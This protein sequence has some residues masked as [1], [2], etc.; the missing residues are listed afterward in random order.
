[1]ND[2]RPEMHRPTVAQDAWGRML[3]FF[4]EYLR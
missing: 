4:R 1:M 2:T 3:G